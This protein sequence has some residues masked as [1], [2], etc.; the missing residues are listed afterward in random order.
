[1]A[2]NAYARSLTQRIVG[3]VARGLVRLGATANWMTLAGVVL[4]LAGAGIV[5]TDRRL[6]GA[7]VIAVGGVADALDG[8]V[9][10]VRGSSG[11]LGS[12][13]DSTADRVSDAGIFGAV[14]WLVRDDPLLFGLGVVGWGSAQTISYMRAKAESLG[15]SATVGLLERAE[16]FIVLLLGIAF[17]LLLPAAL[18]V[19]ALGGLLTVGQRFR[20]VLR[21]AGRI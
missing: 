10:Q 1:M 2:L 9:A 3:P 14:L 6:A 12:F 8:T 5:A 11:K 15:W 4:T 7:L 13:L 21:E 20:A 17:P 19:L 16:R 18:W